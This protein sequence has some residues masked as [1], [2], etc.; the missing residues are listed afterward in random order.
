M[1]GEFKNLKDRIFKFEIF[2]R[3]NAEAEKMVDNFLNDNEK[4]VRIIR[5]EIPKTLW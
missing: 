5:S 1:R 4:L 2:E 3:G